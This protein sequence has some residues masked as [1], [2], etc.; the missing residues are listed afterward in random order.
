MW[1]YGGATQRLRRGHSYRW[2]VWP[3]FGRLSA[4]RYGRLLGQGRFSM[5]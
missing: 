3:G 5:R 4:H 2:F 1:R